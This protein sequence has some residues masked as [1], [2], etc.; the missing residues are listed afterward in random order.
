[1]KV[2]RACKKDIRRR[3]G[4]YSLAF[5]GLAGRG[6]MEVLLFLAGIGVGYEVPAVEGI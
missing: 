3:L 2:L 1:M 5:F 4:S 6:M